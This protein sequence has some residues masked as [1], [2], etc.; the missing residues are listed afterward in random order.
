[1]A[2][3]GADYYDEGFQ[4]ARLVAKILRGAN[5][6]DLPVERANRIELAINLKTSKK[7][8]MAIPRSVL[9]RANEIVK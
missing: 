3:Y 4:A 7:F 8:G 5:T 9:F 1:M 2:S 6:S